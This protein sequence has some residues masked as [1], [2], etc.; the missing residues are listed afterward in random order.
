IDLETRQV[1]AL[2]APPR[3]TTLGIDGLAWYDGSLIG[4]QNGVSPARVIRL[5]LDTA[6]RR[7]RQVEVLDRNTTQAPAPTIGTVW[8][9]RYFY[10]ANSQ[11]EA[12]DD[13]GGLLSG[14]RMDAP[15]ILELVLP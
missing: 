15:R 10:V 8:G 5:V 12:Y 14:V 6:G 3:T 7:I 11:W 2:P 9:G 1:Q 13:A 4:V